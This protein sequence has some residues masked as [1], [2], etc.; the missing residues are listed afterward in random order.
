MGRLAIGET[1]G[2]ARTG[3]PSKPDRRRPGIDRGQSPRPAEPEEKKG[4]RGRAAF[5]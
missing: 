4:R 3:G 5:P 2:L 1:G